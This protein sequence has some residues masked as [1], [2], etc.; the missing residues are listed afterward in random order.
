MDEAEFSR[1]LDSYGRIWESKYPEGVSE[2]YAA[3]VAYH[4][5]PFDDPLVG[6]DQIV[7]ASRLA[8][9]RQEDIKFTHQVLS[10]A[11]DIG[12]ARW[13]CSFTRKATGRKITLDG[14]LL[15][16]FDADGLCYEFREWWHS[17]EPI[18]ERPPSPTKPSA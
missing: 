16:R 7:E 15:A 1:W 11:G 12:I 18:E 3:S 17:D 13:G 8:T 4:W 10:C 6:R 5:T 14:I 2:L 9:S